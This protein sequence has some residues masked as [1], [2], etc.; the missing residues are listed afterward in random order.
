MH[1]RSLTIHAKAAVRP[2]AADVDKAV[3]A[4]RQARPE[5]IIMV[6][7]GKATV[8]FV[9]KYNALGKGM[10]FYALS[11][12]GAQS[13][14]RALG[15]DGI[16]VVVTSAVPF[17]WSQSSPVATEY[18]AAMKRAGFNNLS[19]MGFEAYL[20]AKLMTEGLLRAGRALTRA[21]FV[22]ALETM[23]R[24]DLGGFDVGFSRTSHQGSRFV[25]LTIIGSNERFMN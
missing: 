23:G 3:A 5:V 2:D 9:K 11:V 10:R 13:T 22:S 20:N 14:L 6:T 25:D 7:T 4:L 19:F 18:R 17:P 1:K 8:D 16:G 24:V 21:R 15:A 12:M